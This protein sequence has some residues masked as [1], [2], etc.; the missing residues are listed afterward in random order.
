MSVKVRPIEEAELPTLVSEISAGFLGDSNAEHLEAF[1]KQNME[2]QEALEKTL[3]YDRNQDWVPK[4]LKAS[5]AHD[6]L[7][8]VVG[9]GHLVGDKSVCDLLAKQ[10]WSLKQQ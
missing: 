5:S 10:G 2:G 7:L 8:I 3:L 1:L 4:I 6:T 9:A